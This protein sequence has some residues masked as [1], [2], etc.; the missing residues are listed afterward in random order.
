MNYDHIDTRETCHMP[1]SSEVL[2]YTEAEVARLQ[3]VN[4]KLVEATKECLKVV[5][6]C[7]EATGHIRVAET[8]HQRILIVSALAA[9]GERGRK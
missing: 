7:Y 8:S 9:A 1:T 2:R 5:D 3:E 4:K 6:E